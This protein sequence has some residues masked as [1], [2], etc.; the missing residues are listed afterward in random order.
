MIIRKDRIAFNVI[1][2]LLIS[3]I[4]ILCL[5]PFI[6]VLTGSITS[7]ESILR[8]GFRLFPKEVSYEAY[9]IIFKS[10]DMLVRS[11]I[12]STLVTIVG[13]VMGLFFTAM[14]AYIITCKDFR[15]RDQISFYFYFTTIFG[16][17]LVPWYIL[18]V[19][20]L[21]MKDNYVALVFPL[22]LN[23]IYILIMKSFMKSIP[24]AI[25]ESARIDGAG[26]FMIF[27]K[28]IL[29]LSKPALATIGL[30]IALN[31]WNDWYNAMLFIEKQEM[32]PLQYFLY[33]I[34]SKVDFINQAAARSG[35]PVP[36]MPSEAVKLAMTVVATGPIIF[37]YPFV[38]KYFVK[39]ITIG[40]VKG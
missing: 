31:Y 36:L 15:Y 11:Y 8:D 25:A 4:S 9:T 40:A 35:V 30:F 33:Q 22:L 16:G 23:V 10:P 38:Q 18:L 19:K 32:Y 13:A 5:V 1:G 7:Q 6:M 2:Y 37:L 17:G 29:P 21:H 39:G 24:D 26:D 12:V 27:I 14:T 28:L 20:Y 34:L 3:F